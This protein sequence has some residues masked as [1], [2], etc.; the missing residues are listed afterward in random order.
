MKCPV[1]VH[2]R[3]LA[4]TQK[5]EITRAARARDKE[6]W[7]SQQPDDYDGHEPP[8]SEL[9]NRKE[10]GIMQTTEF[11]CAN[12]MKG[13]IC[14]GCKEVVLE[15]DASLVKGSTAPPTILVLKS[16]GP[17]QDIEMVDGTQTSPDVA[18][19]VSKPTRE[20][21]YRCFTCKR[22]AHYRHLP[23]PDTLELDDPT[24]VDDTQLASFY[25]F[26]TGWRCA[27]C[28]SYEYTVDKILAWRPYPADA[29]EPHYSLTN[30]PDPKSTLPREYLV[31]WNERSYRRVQWVP[32]MWLVST[33]YMKL[34]N[35]ITSGPKVELLDNPVSE[36]KAMEVDLPV[37]PISFEASANQTPEVEAKSVSSLGPL[38][39][40]ERH[41][42]P[43]WKTTDRV[44]DVLFWKVNPSGRG[45]KSKRNSVLE[46]DEVGLP[47]EL[48]DLIV[49][50]QLE[51]EQPSDDYVGSVDDFLRTVGKSQL[52]MKDIKF[53]AWSF[54]KWDDLGYNEGEHILS[55]VSCDI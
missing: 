45:K 25:Q 13:G 21:L 29:I 39:D 33:S 23:I 15:V 2:W 26:E 31:K 32:H 19:S 55:L 7:K 10:L 37:Q 35:F 16:T 4:K 53:V 44:L 46:D 49:K 18:D 47:S 43:A 5:D 30:L 34:K 22:L 52:D 8:D 1:A 41:I 48:E 14:M 36:D 40:A 50:T 9:P 17:T 27:D 54:I 6:E 51:G 24:S 12:C 28:F 11:V 3:C 42:P 38:P 20:L